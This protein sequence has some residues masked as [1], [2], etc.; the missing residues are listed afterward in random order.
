MVPRVN[1]KKYE[2]YAY[3]NF[4]YKYNKNQ[5][6]DDLEKLL[7]ETKSNVVQLKIKNYSEFYR[8]ASIAKANLKFDAIYFMDEVAIII[9]KIK[10]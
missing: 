9:K 8:D 5:G 3:N 1:G 6:F 10:N 7:N 4:V 2:Y